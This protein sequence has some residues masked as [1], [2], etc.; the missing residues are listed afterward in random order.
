MK[1]IA[2]PLVAFTSL[3]FLNSCLKDKDT[4]PIIEVPTDNSDTYLKQLSSNVIQATYNDLSSKSEKLYLAI[5]KFNKSNSDADLAE[6]KT[7]WKSTRQCWEQSESFL[8]GPV[9]TNNIDPRIDTWPVN[10]V[11]LDSVLKNGPTPITA[12]Y[13]DGLEDALKGFHPLEYLLFGKDGAK[14]AAQMTSREKEYL[15]ALADNIKK[16][17]K[18]VSLSWDQTVTN[19]YYDVFTKAGNGSTIYATKIAAYEEVINAM[20]GICD[21]VANG[22]IE[23]PLAANDPSLEE[24]PFAKNSIKDFTDNIIGVQNVYL[25]KYT[26]AGTGLQDLVKANNLSL[27]K[28]VKSALNEAISALNKITDPFGTAITTQKQQIKTAQD[29]I[30]ALRDII[31]GDLKTYVKTQVN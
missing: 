20:A 3:F 13:I 17:T 31:E 8:F 9:S 14:T 18:E 29:K 22:K 30:N 1:K 5:D 26:L 16:L 12:I 21:E 6:C 2:F 7:L 10:Y 25:G 4:D 11:D 27:D 23:D 24:S 28:N 19:N 15:I